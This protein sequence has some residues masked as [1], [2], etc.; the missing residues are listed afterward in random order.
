M[1]ATIDHIA[2]AVENLDEAVDLF[3]KLLGR[4]P[5]GREPVPGFGVE[6]AT[7]EMGETSVE[8]V[9][10]TSEDSPIRRFVQKRGQGIHHIA[11]SVDDLTKAI[12]ELKKKGFDFA[13]ETPREGKDGSRVAFIR[14]GSTGGILFELVEPAH[15]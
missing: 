1:A 15:E 9:E 13:D 14:P 6:T 8:L 4:P 10:G 5:S 11:L 3:E 2:I 12:E 7:F